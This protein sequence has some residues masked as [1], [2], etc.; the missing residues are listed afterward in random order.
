MEKGDFVLEMMSD[1]M[2]DDEFMDY[3]EAQEISDRMWSNITSEDVG[4]DL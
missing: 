3:T 1:L 2:Y 4:D